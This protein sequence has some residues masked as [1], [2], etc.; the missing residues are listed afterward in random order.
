MRGS[1]SG[2]LS[3]NDRVTW[4]VA[5]K[6]ITY[7]NKGESVE[8]VKIE[9]QQGG[10]ATVSAQNVKPGATVSWG[11]AKL[12]WPTTKVDCE[13]QV[14]ATCSNGEKSSGCTNTFDSEGDY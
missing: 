8:D 10:G 6:T 4:D 1:S 9:W 14:T 3:A 13:L 5:K 12:H 11:N 7:T 2:Y